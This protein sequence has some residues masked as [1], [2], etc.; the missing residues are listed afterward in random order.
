VTF[1]NRAALLIGTV[2]VLTGLAAPAAY[3]STPIVVAGCSANGEFA[4]C[5]A[6][7]TARH[8]PLRIVLH[9]RANPPQSVSGAWDMTCSKGTGAGGSSGMY[10]TGTPINRV[11]HKPYRHP[12]S[13]IV[14]ADGQLGRRGKI[15]LW[16][17]YTH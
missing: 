13:C 8:H 15:H 5:S 3:A 2:A 4:I 6:A 17:S 10:H 14:S 7:G 12:D 11:L 16:I 1:R 9:V